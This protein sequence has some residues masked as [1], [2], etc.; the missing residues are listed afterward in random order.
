MNNNNNSDV[1]DGDVNSE[2]VDKNSDV[3]DG[4]DVI[5]DDVDKNSDN[6]VGGGCWRLY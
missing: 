5:S 1:G 3:S 4:I 6:D 2:H